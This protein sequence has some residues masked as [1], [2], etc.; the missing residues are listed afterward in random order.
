[1]NNCSIYRLTRNV[2][3]ETDGGES[4]FLYHRVTKYLEINTCALHN[5]LKTR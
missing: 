5:I 1:M 4:Y 2:Y 3:F